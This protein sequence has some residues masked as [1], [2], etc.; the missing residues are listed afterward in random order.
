MSVRHILA[1][2]QNGNTY[3]HEIF[4]VG[5]HKDSSLIIVTKFRVPG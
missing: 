2:Y 5:C 4:T 1:L 3:D